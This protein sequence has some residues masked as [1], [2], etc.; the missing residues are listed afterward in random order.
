MDL[1]IIG[2][3]VSLKSSD[4]ASTYPKILGRRLGDEINIIE[5]IRAGD[6]VCDLETD[7]IISLDKY[8][9][10]FMILQ[11]G[12]VDCAPRPLKR[13]ERDVLS[14]VRPNWLRNQ[15]IHFIHN[16]RPE[17]IRLRGL[18]QFTPLLLFEQSVR[19]IVNRANL[20]NTFIF[21]LPITRV[22]AQQERR[23]PWYNREIERYN[24]ALRTFSS[25]Q[26]M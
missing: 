22:A 1:L 8:S 16:Y 24:S 20:E 19:L 5:I 7:A 3:S 25:R 6:T 12:H 15:I 10:R 2:N 4:D 26:V 9:P 23:E 18:I 21:I 17:L 11:I 13:W 14:K